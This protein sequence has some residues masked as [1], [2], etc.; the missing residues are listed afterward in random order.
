MIPSQHVGPIFTVWE[1][2]FI[3]NALNS[4]KMIFLVFLLKSLG[5][6]LVGGFVS[7]PLWQ[8]QAFLA[9]PSS[10][11]PSRRRIS[12]RSNRSSPQCFVANPRGNSRL[13]CLSQ[14]PPNILD[15]TEET[16]GSNTR[17][18]KNNSNRDAVIRSKQINGRIQSMGRAGAYKE[19]VE[20]YAVET[21]HF[22]V[23]NYA[24]AINQLGKMR[25]PNNHPILQDPRFHQ[26]LDDIAQQLKEESLETKWPAR[27]RVNVLHG[28]AKVFGGR[29]SSNNN[30]AAKNVVDLILKDATVIIAAGR[31]HSQAIS[32]AA[33][34]CGKLGMSCLEL[35]E[36]INEQAPVL[37]ENASTQSFANIAW[38]FAVLNEQ[39]LMKPIHHATYFEFLETKAKYMVGQ[40]SPTD[41]SGTVWAFASLGLDC[42]NLLEEIDRHVP[43]NVPSW[44]ARQISNVAWACGTLNAASCCSNFFQAIE[45]DATAF[46]SKAS[47]RDVAN[48][49]AAIA[50]LDGINCPA[51]F[52]AIASKAR[53]LVERGNL[54]DNAGLAW[55]FAMVGNLSTPIFGA[56]DEQWNRL[57]RSRAAKSEDI[58][59]II[60][61]FAHL[62]LYSPAL[63]DAMDRYGSMLTFAGKGGDSRV[64][65]LLSMA[66]YGH[67]PT[68][69]VETISFDMSAIVDA[70]N[71]QEITSLCYA[72]AVLDLAKGQK[73]AFRILWNE[74]I[75]IA[76]DELDD[77]K[78]TIILQTYV[79]VSR[80]MEIPPP[81]ELLKV[82][83]SFGLEN[84]D[85]AAQ[86]ELSELLD[87]LGLAHELEASPFHNHDFVPGLLAIDAAWKGSNR[88]AIEFDGPSHFLRD[89]RTGDIL[90][91][92]ENGPTKAKRR[93]L[94]RLGWTVLNINF[95]EWALAG[96]K[97]GRRQI[98]QDKLR[99]IMQ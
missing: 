17:E 64:M 6:L 69:L 26:M 80:T 15:N 3:R 41:I 86:N 12:N 11:T 95:Q 81:L 50:K 59:T 75:K 56:I 27:E 57:F 84:E 97:E 23:I 74:A 51:L 20:L 60:W 53:I 21:S 91:D 32:N 36:A 68:S 4:L 71:P 52:G 44:S 66:T 96:T 90:V 18:K 40:G 48:T 77:E 73:S 19:I 61:A 10:A 13:G 24:T 33:L 34:A 85:S 82:P 58:A 78:R 70:G 88:I 94:E 31:E 99:N 55:G 45:D 47:S 8:V 72:F 25:Q 93:F 35:F 22:S 1:D 92:K 54:Q 79:M 62:R 63:L 28:I 43:E 14:S 46:I 65:A 76:S 16:T 67:V 9:L 38:A 5:L 89:L 98:L 83:L 30:K 37:L 7:C 42:P 39:T 49:V 29:I 87:E 2:C